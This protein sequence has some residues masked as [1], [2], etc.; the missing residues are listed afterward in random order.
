MC[1]PALPVSFPAVRK[2][3]RKTWKKEAGGIGLDPKRIEKSS[4]FRNHRGKPP[5][6]A[7]FVILEICLHRKFLKMIK[8]TQNGVHSILFLEGKLWEFGRLIP[9]PSQKYK[10]EI[11]HSAA[12]VG[13][14]ATSTT[15]NWMARVWLVFLVE[16]VQLD[17]PYQPTSR[18][19]Q[20]LTNQ[21]QL[22][23]PF[24]RPPRSNS[25]PS[26][27]W[28]VLCRLLRISCG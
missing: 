23:V 18:H 16:E 6:L 1:Y 25:H 28:A 3:P 10:G 24:L 2:E 15:L 14:L 11:L 26:K 13:N 4:K 19:S 7:L 8:K 20:L 27:S 21:T 22:S 17:L 5:P 9:P 12:E